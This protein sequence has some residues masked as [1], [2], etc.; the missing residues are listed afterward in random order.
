MGGY[1]FG[2]EP[3][4]LRVQRYG[5]NPPRWPKGASLKIAVLTDIHACRPW[6][7]PDRIRFV[8]K[9]TNALRPDLTVLLGDF[10]AGHRYVTG[11]VH[12]RDWSAA[13]SGL[14]ATLG[15]YSVLGNHDWWEDRTAQTNGHGPTFGQRALEAVGIPVLENQAVRLDIDGTPFWLAGLGDQLA[16]LPWSRY[17]RKHWQGVDNLPGTLAQITDEAPV[18]LLAHEPDVFPKVP[19]RVSL[20]LCGHTHGGQVRVFGYSP[21]VPSSYRNRYAYGH[22][23]ER[24][25]NALTDLVVSG[26]LGCSIAPIRFGVPPEITLV[27]LGG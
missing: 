6:M 4:R 2:V 3:F 7:S 13:L 24:R 10:S 23:R 16:L 8:V 22:I 20:T 12:S 11:D 25:G 21:V 19:A 14:R 18:I 9:Q 15:V 1:A 26:G 17:G 5:I 27:E